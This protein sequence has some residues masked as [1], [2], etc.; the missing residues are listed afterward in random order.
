MIDQEGGSER[1]REQRI[2]Q[3]VHAETRTE[4]ATI[5]EG[6]SELRKRNPGER[7]KEH[8]DEKGKEKRLRYRRNAGYLAGAEPDYDS[9]Q[10]Q[11]GLEPLDDV[12]GNC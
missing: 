3:K 8:D 4:H 1:D 7:G 2:P 5:P 12:H 9:A 10:H 6:S 11:P